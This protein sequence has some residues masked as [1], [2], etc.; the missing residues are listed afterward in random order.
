M[1]PR[2]RQ[3]QLAL[4]AWTAHRRA[5]AYCHTHYGYWCIGGRFLAAALDAVD[6]GHAS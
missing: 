2:Y 1:T 4:A 5:C 6:P 3:V